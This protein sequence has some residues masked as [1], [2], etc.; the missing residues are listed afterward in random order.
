[1]SNNLDYT[2]YQTMSETTV[3]QDEPPATIAVIGAGSYGTAM[4]QIAG[5]RGNIVKIFARDE[6]VV[7]EINENHKNPNY[8][9]DYKLSENISATS[10]VEEALRGVAYCILS[11]PTQI[12]SNILLNQTLN[13]SLITI[14]LT[15][16]QICHDS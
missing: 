5:K 3:F 6:D 8:L 11:L 16:S 14:P 1:M 9:Q 13:I 7:K 15:F 2:Y 4:A 10:S 12:V